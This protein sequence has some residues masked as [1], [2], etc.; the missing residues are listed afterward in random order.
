MA[1]M[2]AAATLVVLVVVL[3]VAGVFSGGGGGGADVG[4]AATA[5]TA[6]SAGIASLPDA[7]ALLR[8]YEQ[9]YEAKDLNGLRALMTSDVV[10]KRGPSSQRSGLADVTAAYRQEFQSFGGKQPAFD[11]SEGGSD[12]SQDR[13]EI[14]GPYSI[15]ANGVQREQGQFGFLAQAVGPAVR[16]KELCFDCPDLHHAGGFLNS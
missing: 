4:G 1:L 16:I 15:S 11:W 10:L 9:T 13:A 14:H 2:A 7:E 12:S 5:G 6:I 8:K 3:A